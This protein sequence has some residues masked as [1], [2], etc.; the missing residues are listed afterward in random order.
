MP[1]ARP[2]K[3]TSWMAAISSSVTGQVATVSAQDFFYF[4][5]TAIR[6]ACALTIG[7]WSSPAAGTGNAGSLGGTVRRLRVRRCSESAS[8]PYE[9]A[10]V[11]SNTYR[12]GSSIMRSG[13][14]R[15]SSMREGPGD[16][17]GVSATKKPA[18]FTVDQVL[19]TLRKS[20]GDETI[21]LLIGLETP[22]NAQRTGADVNADE[23]RQG[24]KKRLDSCS[25]TWARRPLK[26]CR[27]RE[28]PRSL[29]W[30]CVMGSKPAPPSAFGAFG[31]ARCGTS[32]VIFHSATNALDV[33][34]V[35]DLVP[36]LLVVDGARALNH[37]A[38]RKA[39]ATLVGRGFARNCAAARWA[40]P[41]CRS[42]SSRM[43]SRRPC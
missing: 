21:A 43:Q 9:R 15:R 22:A 24:A 10:D 20:E 26:P 18:S 14:C 36:D 32:G 33:P 7:R 3:S 1:A 8:D 42:I 5:T 27:L 28:V 17:Q 11:T 31:S 41:M 16:V 37:E 2:I 35:I 19:E 4:R 23:I 12:T 13:W 38:V 25:R 34:V 6:P 40:T 39:V 30:R 29:P